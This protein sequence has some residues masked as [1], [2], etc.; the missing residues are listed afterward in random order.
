MCTFPPIWPPSSQMEA[1]PDAMNRVRKV[2]TVVP[3]FGVNV[4][5]PTIDILLR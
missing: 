2:C 5:V 3:R 4:I 1:L